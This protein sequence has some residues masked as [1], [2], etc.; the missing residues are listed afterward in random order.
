MSEFNFAKER[1]DIQR[2]MEG[3]VEVLH[4]EFA[5]LR[6]GRAATSLLEPITVD[7]YGSAMPMN[8]VGTIGVPEP[9]MLTVQVWDKSL[10]NAVD[11]AI[12]ESD[13]GLNP[14]IDGQIVRVPIPALTEER[15]TEF[16]KIASKYAE[17]ARVAVRNVRR[18]A[19]DELKR[20]EKDHEI[21]EDEHRGYSDEVQ[22]MT[23]D[24]VG[25]IDEAL[26][27]KESEIMQV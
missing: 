21:S 7:A 9:R 23:D 10:V 4:K 1:K 8:Q 11:K 25:K 24:T 3:A 2:R 26:S 18:H 13:L 15:R 6:S 19:M 27:N 22:K 5:G 16:T 12:R 14:Q 17:E 20:A